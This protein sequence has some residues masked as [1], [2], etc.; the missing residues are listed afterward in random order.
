MSTEG[1]TTPPSS[2]EEF[3]RRLAEL[4]QRQFSSFS[5]GV[6]TGPGA[7]ELEPEEPETGF[8]FAAKPREV[9]A[10]LDRFVIRQ[11]EA[12]KVLSVALCD[13]YN[14]VRQAFDGEEQGHYTK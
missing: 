13:H 12:K 5:T 4:M 8:E 6:A 11:D 14:A 3:Q 2:P 1:P 10:H 7:P 9:K